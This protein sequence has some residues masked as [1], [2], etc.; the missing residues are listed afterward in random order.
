MS[1]LSAVC[2]DDLPGDGGHVPWYHQ[3]DDVSHG[4]SRPAHR[5][6]SELHRA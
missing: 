4:E 1:F 2:G 6:L 5:G 3:C